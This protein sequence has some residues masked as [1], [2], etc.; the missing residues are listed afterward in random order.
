MLE[1]KVCTWAQAEEAKAVMQKVSAA[2][3][4]FYALELGAS[5]LIFLRRKKK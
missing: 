4:A 3:F 1:I 5:L 2:F